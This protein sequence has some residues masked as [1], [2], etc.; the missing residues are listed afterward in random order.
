M[1]KIVIIVISILLVLSITASGIGYYYS[2][3]KTNDNKEENN[4]STDKTEE[5]IDNELEEYFNKIGKK[6]NNIYTTENT[7]LKDF[8]FDKE[9]EKLFMD[10]F[11]IENLEEYFIDYDSLEVLNKDLIKNWLFAY[12]VRNQN[13]NE[14][15][16]SKELLINT[17][18]KIFD[19]KDAIEKIF[20]ENEITDN[21]VCYSKKKSDI[22][23]YKQK[24]IELKN[25]GSNIT[26]LSDLNTELTYYE[27]KNN[28]NQIYY[29]GINL[30]DYESVSDLNTDVYERHIGISDIDVYEEYKDRY[31]IEDIIIDREF[32]KV[33]NIEY[34]YLIDDTRFYAYTHFINSNGESSFNDFDNIKMTLN[35]GKVMLNQ[36]GKD[37]LIP[38]DNV[39]KVYI[40]EFY[41]EDFITY[42]RIYLL[43][44]LGE[45]Y[46]YDEN[47]FSFDK[48][49]FKNLESSLNNYKKVELDNKVKDF[50]FKII[51]DTRFD[52]DNIIEILLKLED[53]TLYSIRNNKTI[54]YL[55]NL[56]NN[57]IIYKNKDVEINNKTISYKFG[58]LYDPKLLWYNANI[59]YFITEDNYLYDV[60]KNKLLNDSKIDKIYKTNEIGC[61]EERCYYY[62]IINFVN[63]E[64]IGILGF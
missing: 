60:N 42:L 51:D 15:C 38:L 34:S 16:F 19:E 31:K 3:N 64:S 5:I 32:D 27:L 44:E 54:N 36:S 25:L 24:H 50:V 7:E 22:K 21:Y 11:I 8:T 23:E 61:D 49:K 10:N 58:T 37:F 57:I 48:S 45:V 14:A 17:Y 63:S 59:N 39:K 56:P 18:E 29:I 40:E 9:T 53:D 26:N 30:F 55:V 4:N 33:G 20:N 6:Y 46:Y 1:K 62:F 13:I 47:S 12:I 43:N 2:I 28:K 41:I 52:S 35:N